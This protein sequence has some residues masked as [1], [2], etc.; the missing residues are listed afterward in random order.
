MAKGFLR[1]MYKCAKFRTEM[2]SFLTLTEWLRLRNESILPHASATCEMRK[3]MNIR[4]M[5]SNYFSSRQASRTYR[6]KYDEQP[7][8]SLNIE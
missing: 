2:H 3:G 7:F 6:N 1:Y 8:M 5:N 4:R